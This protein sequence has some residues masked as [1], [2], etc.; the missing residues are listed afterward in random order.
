[1]QVPLL[2]NRCRC[3][4]QQKMTAISQGI[5][6]MEAQPKK[7]YCFVRGGEMAYKW[8]FGDVRANGT[9]CHT[10]GGQLRHKMKGESKSIDLISLFLC[11][12]TIISSKGEKGEQR[13]KRKRWRERKI[14]F[15]KHNFVK[16]ISY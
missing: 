7:S 12:S 2:I 6:T 11:P 14:S 13:A 8:R 5:K 16:Y 15:K 1:M 3:T 9:P 4:D 10:V